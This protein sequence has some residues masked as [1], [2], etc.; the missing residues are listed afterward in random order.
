MPQT[1][2]EAILAR[3]D[4]QRTPML[5]QLPTQQYARLLQRWKLP[6]TINLSH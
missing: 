3:L 6:T 5:V 2:L 1:D 4:P